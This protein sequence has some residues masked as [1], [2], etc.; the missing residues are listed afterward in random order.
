MMWLKSVMG[1]SL[2]ITCSPRSTAV[3]LRGEKE[4]YLFGFCLVFF[5]FSSRYFIYFTDCIHANDIGREKVEEEYDTWNCVHCE[6]HL[7]HGCWKIIRNR[8]SHTPT[9][10]K[11][12][13][14]ASA[15]PKNEQGGTRFALW[16]YGRCTCSPFRTNI[17]TSIVTWYHGGKAKLIWLP[18][19]FQS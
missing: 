17:Q 4:D 5:F 2:F 3:H 10:S 16:Q 18:L 15:L 9:N 8:L 14:E 7:S 19:P 1:C 11:L 13:R 12:P 6:A